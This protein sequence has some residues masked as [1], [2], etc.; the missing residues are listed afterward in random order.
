VVIMNEIISRLDLITDYLFSN[1]ILKTTMII[2][3]SSLLAIYF[4]G[5]S[6]LPIAHNTFHEIR[7]SLGLLCH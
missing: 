6:E 2:L 4:V 7:H 5:F 3:F 1:I